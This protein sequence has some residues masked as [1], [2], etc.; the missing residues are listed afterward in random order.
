MTNKYGK[1]A[2]I[3]MIVLATVIVS[4]CIGGD[5]TN[6]K[7][8]KEV[9]V[10]GVTFFLPDGYNLQTSDKS[11]NVET[12]VYDNGNDV[13]GISFAPI[14]IEQSLSNVKSDSSFSNI[15]EDVSFAGYSGFTAVFT[16][17]DS[18]KIKYFI[19]EKSGKVFMISVSNEANFEEYV[20]KIIGN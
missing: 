7:F 18:L 12:H 16:T 3:L 10:G 4:G 5:T 15:Q 20:P 2:L 17:G 19:F 14:S 13:I 6:D 8:T 11:G 1:I 9:S